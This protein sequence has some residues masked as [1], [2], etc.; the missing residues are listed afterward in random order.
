MKLLRVQSQNEIKPAVLDQS[1]AIRDLS[2]ITGNFNGHD[3]TFSL[4]DKVRAADI[5]ALPVITGQII[6]PVL[7]VPNFFCIGLNY[8]KHAAETG[9][10][11]P[12]EPM[13]FNKSTAALCGAFDNIIVPRGSKG[14]DW[15]VELGLMIG[16]PCYQVSE[17]EALDYVF[18][19]FTA[20]DVSEREFQK[21]R[22]GQF[23]KGKSGLNAGPIGPYIVTAD[24]VPD[25]QN[26]DIQTKVNGQVMQSSN[27]DDMIF[28]VRQIIS[29]LSQYLQLRV[30]DVIITGTPEGVA[31]GHENP[32][33]L[34][35]GDIV[36]VE[37][38]G[39]GAQRAKVVQG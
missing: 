19:Y 12:P 27:T 14:L 32:P 22:G 17:E 35:D 38:E 10:R 39:L 28:S 30:G 31:M 26:L 13:L 7:D 37:V 2:S 16:K 15:E 9:S 23:V 29:N 24:E 18:G 3:M 21:S 20:N 4:L 1:G 34:Q 11:L 36:E 6:Q 33:F 25:P 8:A 5:S